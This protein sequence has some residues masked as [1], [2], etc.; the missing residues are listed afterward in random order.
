[1]RLV[2]LFLF[3]TFF[4]QFDLYSQQHLVES[5]FVNSKGVVNDQMLV[6]HLM[7]QRFPGYKKRVQSVFNRNKND[8]L[9][10]NT[11]STL[12]NVNVVFHVVYQSPEENIPD[13]VIYSQV[14]VLNEDYQRLNSDTTNLRSIFHS[15]VGKPNIQFNVAQIVRVPTTSSFSVGLSGLPD[16]VK[17]TANGGS[18]AWNTDAYLNIWICKLES[19]LGALFGY[20]YP[21]AGL[22][23]WPSGSAAPSSELDGVVLDYRAVGRNNPNPFSNGSGGNFVINGRTATHEVGHY[24]GM[25]HIWGDGGGIFGGNSCNE[26]DGINDTPNQGAQSSNNCDTTLN[27]CIDSIGVDLPDLIENHMDYSDEKCKNMSTQQQADFMRNVLE[28][29]RAGLLGISQTTSFF[30]N[31]L[32][33]VYPNPAN[34]FLFIKTLTSLKEISLEFIDIH[35]KIIMKKQLYFQPENQYKVKTHK[36]NKGLYFLNIKSGL[37]TSIVRVLIN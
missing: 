14:D 30:E 17:Q 6:M 32:V 4:S 33:E 9:N 16:N 15:I 34:D 25:R 29:E 31:D 37:N 24:F 20:A 2:Y 27:T 23:N 22:S 11:K 21:P 28:N 10:K 8:H 36:L 18:D 3:A 12:H 13:S 26:D 5:D 7:E 35:G 19:F 1:M